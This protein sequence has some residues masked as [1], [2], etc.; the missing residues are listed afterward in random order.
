MNVPEGWKLV[1]I[2]PTEAQLDAVC[3]TVHSDRTAYRGV[4]RLMVDAAPAP[5]SESL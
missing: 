2:A 4:Y 5:P 1:P 3:N